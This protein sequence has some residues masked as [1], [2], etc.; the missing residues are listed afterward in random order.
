MGEPIHV[1]GAVILRERRVLAALR[2][3][4]KHLAGYW[5]FPGGKVEDGEDEREALRRELMEELAI[6]G[7]VHERLGEATHR[8]PAVTVRL[9][10]YV[11]RIASGEPVAI[12]H[13]ELRWVDTAELDELRWAPG[14]VPFLPAVRTRLA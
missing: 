9:V 3:P 12:E 10:A 4:G 2:G 6:E 1:V 5:E 14:D 8:Y 13:A 11:V 7:T